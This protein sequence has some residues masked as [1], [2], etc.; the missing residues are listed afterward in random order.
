VR[1]TPGGEGVLG[2]G[3]GKVVNRNIRLVD[4]NKEVL[5]KYDKGKS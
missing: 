3:W 5:R 1:Q 2:Q 4:A